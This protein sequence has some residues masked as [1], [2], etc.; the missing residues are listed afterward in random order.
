[1]DANL[2]ETVEKKKEDDAR[3]IEAFRKIR[4]DMEKEKKEEQEAAY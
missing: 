2:K 1:M 4:T 3:R